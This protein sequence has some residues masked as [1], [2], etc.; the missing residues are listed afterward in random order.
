MYDNLY[1]KKTGS[2]L[3]FYATLAIIWHFVFLVLISLYA[4]GVDLLQQ[5]LAFLSIAGFSVKTTQRR[6]A[7]C[8]P[9]PT[10]PNSGKR[11]FAARAKKQSS[12]WT[13]VLCQ[14]CSPGPASSPYQPLQLNFHLPVC[15]TIDIHMP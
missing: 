5:V 14:S 9:M 13:S 4:I 3:I 12:E 6:L 15:H 2:D 10:T 7:R 11:H 8:C 1:D